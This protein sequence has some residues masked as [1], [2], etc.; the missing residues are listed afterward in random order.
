MEDL[1]KA[2]KSDSSKCLLLTR[3]LEKNA[4][5][6]KHFC[7]IFLCSMCIIVTTSRLS[8][9]KTTFKFDLLANNNINTTVK[10]EY[11]YKCI[12]KKRLQYLTRCMVTLK[13][14]VNED[15]TKTN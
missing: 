4:C 13:N 3:F 12:Y 2:H 9:I 6:E 1:G 15:I 8:V 14:C 10:S 11:V 7:N 5:F